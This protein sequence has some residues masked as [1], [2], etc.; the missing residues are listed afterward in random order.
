MMK[1]NHYYALSFKESLRAVCTIRKDN[2]HTQT[3]L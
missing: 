2:L 1:I 3:S